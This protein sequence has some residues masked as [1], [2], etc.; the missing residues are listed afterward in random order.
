MFV[1]MRLIFERATSGFVN[2]AKIIQGVVKELDKDEKDTRVSLDKL[3]SAR[4][5]GSSLCLLRMQSLSL[6]QLSNTSKHYP[7]LSVAL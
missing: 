2:I 6:T 4:S 3:Y 5:S 1:G 7:A